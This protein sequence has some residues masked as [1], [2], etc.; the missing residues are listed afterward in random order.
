[1]YVPHFDMAFWSI[2][3]VVGV[4]YLWMQMGTEYGKASVSSAHLAKQYFMKQ[5]WIGAYLI[6]LYLFW[7]GALTA[8]M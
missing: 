6:T 2:S 7:S 8:L 5:K 3:G 4:N 1:M